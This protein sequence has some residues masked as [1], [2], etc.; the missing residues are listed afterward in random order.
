MQKIHEKENYDKAQM[1]K[2]KKEI[3]SMNA[4][5]VEAQKKIRDLEEKLT[6]VVSQAGTGRESM[7]RASIANNQSRQSRTHAYFMKIA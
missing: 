5:E 3:E 7:K 6:D 1:E 4:R 2:V